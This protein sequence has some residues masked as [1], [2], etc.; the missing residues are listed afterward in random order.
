MGIGSKLTKLMKEQNTNA[1]E[2]AQ[3]ADVPAQTIYSLIRRDA[4]KVD[5][6][7]LIKIARATGVTAEYFCSDDIVPPDTSTA[8][9]DKPELV[10][11]EKYRALD[12]HGKKSVDSIINNELERCTAEYSPAIRQHFPLSNNPDITFI[13]YRKDYAEEFCKGSTTNRFFDLSDVFGF[14]N[15]ELSL[16]EFEQK[17]LTKSEIDARFS[18]LDSFSKKAIRPATGVLNNAA[19]E[20]TDIEVTDD[21]KKH[22]NDIMDDENF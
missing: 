1:N 10:I 22:D 16:V 7:S 15:G 18:I 4:S 6:D 2:L 13:L 9:F 20:R 21:M 17:T 19:H 3:K 12:K 5:I 8:S 14:F 11:I